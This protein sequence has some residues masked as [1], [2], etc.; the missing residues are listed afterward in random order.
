MISC[1]FVS[2]LAGLAG[3]AEICFERK[4]TK[5]IN[6]FL[7]VKIEL[8]EKPLFGAFKYTAMLI[9]QR[10]ICIELT[11]GDFFPLF[12]SLYIFLLP[13]FFQ[14]TQAKSSEWD[15]LER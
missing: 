6:V 9:E 11:F 7:E 2:R 14:E 8:S 1:A 5:K 10:P 12:S 3:L 15:K 13:S 4:M